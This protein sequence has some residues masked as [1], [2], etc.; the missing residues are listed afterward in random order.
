VITIDPITPE[1]AL[2]FKAAR[3]RALEDVPSAFGSTYAKES[4][5]TD[6][7]WINRSAQWNGEKSILYLAMEDG[8]ASGIAGSHLDRDDRARAHLISM[9]TAPTYRQRGIGRLLVDEIVR[10]A[11]LR[12]ARTL[13]L[14]VTS[15]NNSALLFYQRLGFTFTGRTA[16]YPNDPTLFELE[17]S[18]PIP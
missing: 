1:N 7:D 12:G 5:L 3:L 18:R 11:C 15:G 17:M 6:A 2:L 13:Q 9:W 4:Q 16:P 8:V 14:M 10:W